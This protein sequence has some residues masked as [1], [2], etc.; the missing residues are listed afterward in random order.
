MPLSR[1]KPSCSTGTGTGGS[2]TRILQWQGGNVTEINTGI[3]H[4]SQPTPSRDGR[5]ITFSGVDPQRP[6]QASTD[7]FLFDR[8]TGPSRM[9]RILAAEGAPT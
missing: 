3:A 2:S 7:L 8:A 6:N 1:R 5:F 9:E 4:S